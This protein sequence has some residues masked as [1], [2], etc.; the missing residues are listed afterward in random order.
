MLSARRRVIDSWHAAR[1]GRSN[2]EVCGVTCD[3]RGRGKSDC[4]ELLMRRALLAVV[5]ITILTRDAT[6]V[7]AADVAASHPLAGTPALPPTLG[8]PFAV[9]SPMQG[10][11][12][13]ID[14]DPSLLRAPGVRVFDTVPQPHWSTLIDRLEERR[15]GEEGR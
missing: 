6:A 8:V 14:Q 12:L 13:V 7:R 10:R 3:C 11:V 9:Y 5:A 2:K 1:H 15:V 4:Q